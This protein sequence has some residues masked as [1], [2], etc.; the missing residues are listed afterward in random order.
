MRKKRK[1]LYVLGFI[2]ALYMFVFSLTLIKVSSASLGE[3]IFSLTGDNV[4]EI[5]A[6]GLGWLAT[7]ITQS[8]GAAAA[9]LI[10]FSLVGIIGPII[11][12]Y[13]IIGTRIGT[14]ITALFTAFLVHAKRRDFRHGFE[15][16]LAN[17][18]YAIPIAIVMFLLEFFTG[19]F[20]KIGTYFVV[21]D[22]PF[23]Y[24]IVDMVV[25]PVINL[26]SFIPNHLNLVLGIFL[27][28]G[29][30]KY[31]P[32]FMINIW[33]EKHLKRKINEFLD[34]KWKSF[35]LGLGITA[36]LMSTSITITFLIPL[37]I[38]RITKLKNVIPYMIGA[39]LGGVSEIILGGLVLGGRAL[40]AIFTYVSF[41]LLGLLWMFNTDLM[42]KIT[43]FISKRTL[44]ISRKR[45]LMF[46]VAFVLVALI[47]SFI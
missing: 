47:L 3:G 46:I 2:L 11:L 26:F 15:I 12:L 25:L 28:V 14:S 30:L 5:N 7:L 10:A 43:K 39:N 13:M 17:L 31:I 1:I 41:S 21:F 6:F 38:T 27:L 45:A 20:H 4:S 18:V 23:K 35:L 33:G 40:P 44:R 24:N 32:K 22:S 16:G 9:I 29:S 42:F 19:F 36:L 34:K 8:S 37:V